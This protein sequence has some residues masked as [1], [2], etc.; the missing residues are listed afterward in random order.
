M[1]RRAMRER[2]RRK[3][4]QLRRRR[5]IKL[6]TYAVAA[7]LAVI[8]VVRGVIIPIAQRVGGGKPGETQEVQAEPV[9][10]DPNAA[11]RQPLKGQG[12]VSKV[13]ALTPGWHEDENGRW[14]QNADGTYF[15]GGFQEIS[16]VQYFFNDNGYIQ[17]GWVTKGVNDYYFNDDGSYNPEKKRPLLALTFDDGPGEY[18]EELLDCLEENNAHATFFMLGQKVQE[19]PDTVKRMLEL[20][21]E[22]GSHSWDHQN[23]YNLDMDGV[24][25]QFTDTDNALIEACGQAATVARAPYGNWNSDIIATVGKPFFMWSLDSLDWDLKDVELDYNSVMNG[26]LTDGSVIL[27]HDIHQPSVE[28]AKRLIPDLIAKGYKLVTVS[29]MAEAKN[30]VLQNASYSDFWQSSLDRGAVAGYA[31]NS[32][33]GSTDT[34]SE[35]TSDG[36]SEGFEDGDDGNS[37]DFTSDDGDGTEDG[38]SDGE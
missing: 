8:F 24:S 37:E 34:S 2:M 27:M 1:D 11:V 4:R 18:T 14:Y 5:I 16:G 3:Q 30:V 21:C 12:D 13:S 29:E 15:A 33:E 20:G 6:V 9:A 31:G 10:A 17:T 32:T 25:K 38:F 23:L 28:A 19:Y 35:E 36:D 22:I 26:D 7:V